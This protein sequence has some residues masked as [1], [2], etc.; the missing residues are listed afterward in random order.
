M[1]ESFAQRIPQ[2]ALTAADVSVAPVLFLASP[3]AAAITGHTLFADGG[4]SAT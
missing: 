1:I 4:M 2:G 3:Q